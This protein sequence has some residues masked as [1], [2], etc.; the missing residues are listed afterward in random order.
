MVEH[1][2][3]HRTGSGNAH[4]PDMYGNLKHGDRAGNWRSGG[5]RDGRR[6]G[7]GLRPGGDLVRFARHGNDRRHVGIQTLG[8][9]DPGAA[10]FDRQ[11]IQ[12]IIRHGF[13]TFGDIEHQNP[14]QS[15]PA[16]LDKVFQRVFPVS[17]EGRAVQNSHYN[18][19]ARMER[20]ALY[21]G[22]ETDNERRGIGVARGDG[23]R[24]RVELG[25]GER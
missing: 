2:A 22:V 25:W 11:I 4:E 12:G 14:Y 7:C 3:A 17:G 10:S 24:H 9:A 6:G 20:G 21:G 15:V 8:L 18:A 1:A 19:R 13:G 16:Y 5:L 23:L